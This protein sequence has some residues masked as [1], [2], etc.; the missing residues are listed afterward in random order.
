MT[1]PVS[2]DYH[3][4][5]IRLEEE[6]NSCG[7]GWALTAGGMISRTINAKDD[8]GGLY[9]GQPV[10]QIQGN[11]IGYQPANEPVSMSNIQLNSTVSYQCPACSAYYKCLD[12]PINGN[13][14]IF[15]FNCRYLVN[16][17]DGTGD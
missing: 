3:T 5:G 1:I 6:A 10:P 12:C 14:Y 4:G 15:N 2:I 8:L 16:F 11:L 7:L 9:F 13:R 17:T